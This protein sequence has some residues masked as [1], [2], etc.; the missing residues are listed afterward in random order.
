MFENLLDEIEAEML[1]EAE[2]VFGTAPRQADEETAISFK[3]IM[4][5]V[6]H[7]DMSQLVPQYARLRKE[8]GRDFLALALLA[9]GYPPETPPFLTGR[10]H[11]VVMAAALMT[12]PEKTADWWKVAR[13]LGQ[14]QFFGLDTRNALEAVKVTRQ[15]TPKARRFVQ[16][17][18]QKYIDHLQMADGEWANRVLV[19][20]RSLKALVEYAKVS[21]DSE[22]MAVLRDKKAWD[23]NSWPRLKAAREF[24]R[25]VNS[26]DYIAAA[27]ILKKTK[28]PLLFIEGCVDIARSEIAAAAIRNA[29]PK[30]VMARLSKL[31]RSGALGDRDVF[32]AVAGALR[33]AVDDPRVAPADLRRVQD[34]ANRDLPET[35]LQLLAEAEEKKRQELFKQS[36][37]DLSL[38]QICLIVDKS[39]SMNDAITAA[40]QMAAYFAGQGAR[41]KA[42]RFDSKAF[43]IIPETDESGK[44]DWRRTFGGIRAGGYTSIGAALKKAAEIAPAA[45]LW[46]VLTDGACNTHPYADESSPIPESGRIAVVWFGRS[47]SQG[48]EK[49]LC[50]SAAEE[51]A[52]NMRD[53]R[54]DYAALDDLVRLCLAGDRIEE[55]VATLPVNV[56]EMLIKKA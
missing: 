22:Y 8:M 5:T 7:G 23:D 18:V 28:L 16:N 4:S 32:E 53:G 37:I 48:F 13:L 51:F 55:W 3:K 2:A 24:V 34:L 6:P 9:G 27:N 56:V 11:R 36:E 44:P 33:R 39:G 26:N 17:T 15:F 41:V 40:G 29:T 47:P 46:V 21:V 49:W 20:S 10:D 14:R 19:D 42:I 43:E 45:D 1:A 54:L 25:L 12:Y 38:K 31:A 52:P 35:I 30:Q 50:W